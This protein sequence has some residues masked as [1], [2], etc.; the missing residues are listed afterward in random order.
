MKIVNTTLSTLVS[1]ASHVEVEHGTL[2]SKKY[3]K[4]NWY[5]S[6]ICFVYM[7]IGIV[8]YGCTLVLI[9]WSEQPL[10]K[11]S[12]FNIRNGSRIMDVF[13]ISFRIRVMW[14]CAGYRFDEIFVLDEN[15]TPV[16]RKYLVSSWAYRNIHVQCLQ[17]WWFY[18]WYIWLL[19][20]IVDKLDWKTHGR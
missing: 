7:F 18:Q 17:S 9:R 12:R 19:L 16:L 13:E 5:F 15:W 4:S 1:F 10:S 8:K 6:P 3:S 14:Y 20:L 2:F 11:V